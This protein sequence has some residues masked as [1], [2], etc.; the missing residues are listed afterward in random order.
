MGTSH[1]EAIKAAFPARMTEEMKKRFLQL[2]YD[3]PLRFTCI[4]C[5]RFDP[6]IDRQSPNPFG[7]Y[8][9]VTCW[10]KDNKPD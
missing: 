4:T 6:Y 2:I 7:W 3:T 5:G 10:E 9:N 1:G 8:C